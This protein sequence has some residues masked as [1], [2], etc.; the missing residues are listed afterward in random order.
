MDDAFNEIIDMFFAE[1][2]QNIEDL[3]ALILLISEMPNSA[4]FRT[5]FRL[6]HNLKGSSKSVGFA[7][8]GKI[9]HELETIL[10]KLGDG[11]YFLTPGLL[12]IFLKSIDSLKLLLDHAIAH[13]NDHVDCSLIL[14]ELQKWVPETLPSDIPLGGSSKGVSSKETPSL[15]AKPAHHS[16]SKA[17]DFVRV[18]VGRIDKLQNHV[19]EL[20][21]IGS[22]LNEQF[23]TVPS[24]Q[25]KSSLR[26]LFK[27]TKEIQD[28]AMGLRMVSLKSLISRLKRSVQDAA[29]EL[30]KEV[31]FRVEGESLEVDKMIAEGLA[32][33]LV[34]MV[35]NSVDHGL[36]SMADRRK[37]GKPGKGL[38]EL[39]AKIEGGG[40]EITLKDDGKGLNPKIILEKAIEKG[41]VSSH[42]PLTESQIFELIFKPGFSTKEQISEISGRGVGMDVVKTNLDELRGK[43]KIESKLGEGTQFTI[44]IP[45]SLSIISGLIVKCKSQTFVIPTENI[46]YVTQVSTSKLS[47][48]LLPFEG[49]LI[50]SYGESYVPVVNLDEVLQLNGPTLS[51]APSTVSLV[52]VRAAHMTY[53]LLVDTIIDS[54]DIVVKPL[55]KHLSHLKVYSGST[56]LGEGEIC[57]ILDLRGISQHNGVA[58]S[59]FSI[60]NATKANGAPTTLKSSSTQSPFVVTFSLG[61]D[62]KYALPQDKVFRLE[63]FD[64]SKLQ[65]T[66]KHLL[67][68]YRDRSVPLINLKEL[69]GLSAPES[70][71]KAMIQ[72]H[73]SG[74]KLTFTFIITSHQD[75]WLALM[76]D[77]ILDI[78]SWDGNLK[79]HQQQNPYCLGVSLIAGEAYT[80]IHLEKMFL[81]EDLFKGSKPIP[82]S[83]LTVAAGA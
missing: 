9:T 44:N 52:V 42:H 28:E 54:E 7:R 23:R 21:M 34:H 13:R 80:L 41:I 55:C 73:R 8:I 14:E 83:P 74:G 58:N 5:M 61:E 56:F 82:H 37:Q 33:P 4:H 24:S 69:L 45:L 12:Q 78:A 64:S 19:G 3:E 72:A 15:D 26:H 53:A 38:I 32:D 51:T 79:L 30:K 20:L 63:V 11:T 31:E 77:K 66:Q 43:I 18:G 35:R 81:G 70:F 47:E 22:A 25:V 6:A 59:P 50:M 46:L 76:V 48:R 2:R 17:E 36:E 75:K 71:R 29:T 49:G 39:K 60:E 67:V 57:M 65:F 62:I 68:R 27:A 16:V 10:L 1:T 40:I